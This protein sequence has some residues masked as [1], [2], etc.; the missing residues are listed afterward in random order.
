M[1]RVILPPLHVVSAMTSR[2]LCAAAFL[3]GTDPQREF[4]ASIRPI[5]GV[6]LLGRRLRFSID[7]EERQVETR[8]FGLFRHVARH[9]PMRGVTLLPRDGRTPAPLSPAAPPPVR[10]AAE[11][12]IDPRI[13]NILANA[14]AE[15][16]G[17]A[18]RNTG[19]VVAMRDGV[20][21]GERYAEGIG[22][23]TPLLG[24]S[25]A[26]ALN[27]AA[28]AALVRRGVLA[29][30]EDR[31]FPEWTAPG[32]ARAGITVEHLLRMTSGLANDETRNGY[33]HVTRMLFLEP[34]MGA[35]AATARLR[36]APGTHW[37]YSSGN[38][39]LL[40][41]LMRERLGGIDAV[42]RFL[43]EAVFAPLGMASAHIDFDAAGTPILSTYAY[44]TA[45]DWARLG[46]LFLDDGVVDGTRILPEGWLARATV[47]HEASGYGTAL[48]VNSDARVAPRWRL[49]GAPEDAVF[50]HGFLGQYVVTVPSRR[51]I[52]ARLGATH[53]ADL[54]DMAGTVRDV[55]AALSR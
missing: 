38:T 52:V 25:L 11:P 16:S 23:D 30:E 34:D 47:P 24:Y 26:K 41:R 15:P 42:H 28:V 2:L 39:I 36:R 55:V 7:E 48:R 21:I 46:R 40:A 45:R 12:Q 43:A 9:D 54:V 32:D 29:L 37:L 35:Y 5:R 22:P 20:V 1:P 44:A 4:E 18:R 14:F 50:A 6:K 19:A 3:S 49:P 17:E 53:R 27:G 33:D 51:L 31:L 8:I 10:A 13:D